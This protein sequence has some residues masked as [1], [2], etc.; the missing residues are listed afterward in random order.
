MKD[1]E[2]KNM[3]SKSVCP[4]GKVGLTVGDRDVPSTYSGNL[5][6]QAVEPHNLAAVAVSGDR[7]IGVSLGQCQSL[8]CGHPGGQEQDRGRAWPTSMAVGGVPW[9]LPEAIL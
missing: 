8:S 3:N 9:V 1:C 2:S 6:P 5:A 4:R 7:D